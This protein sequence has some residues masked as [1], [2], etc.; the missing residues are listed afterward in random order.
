MIHACSY[1][2]TVGCWEVLKFSGA[3]KPKQRVSLPEIESSARLGGTVLSVFSPE[4]MELKVRASGLDGKRVSFKTRLF[5]GQNRL[6]LTDF[7]ALPVGFYFVSISTN[8][9]IQVVKWVKI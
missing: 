2:P 5:E 3:E 1:L 9:F 4:E 6:T 7:E 8:E